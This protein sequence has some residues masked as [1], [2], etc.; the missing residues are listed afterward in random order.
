[1]ILKKGDVTYV[2]TDAVQIKALITGGYAESTEDDKPVALDKL[3]KDKL[4]ELATSKGIDF[5]E[6]KTK[7]DIIALINDF[8]QRAE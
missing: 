4:E 5:S 2:V 6:A 8:E 7:A 3:T 1:M